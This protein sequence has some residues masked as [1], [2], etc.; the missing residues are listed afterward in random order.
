MKNSVVVKIMSPTPI[1]AYVLIPRICEYG[2]LSGKR[3]FPDKDLETDYFLFLWTQFF[4]WDFKIRE[5]FPALGTGSCDCDYMRMVGEGLLG[6]SV[7]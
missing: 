4:T 2:T 3:D 7:G 1:H 6:G 5:P